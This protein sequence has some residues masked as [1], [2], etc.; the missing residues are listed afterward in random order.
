MEAAVCVWKGVFLLKGDGAG[1]MICVWR[2]GA[3]KRKGED[4]AG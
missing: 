1:A 4:R 3:G 2:V